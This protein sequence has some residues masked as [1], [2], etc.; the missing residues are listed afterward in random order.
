M[1]VAPRA[2]LA[3]AVVL[4]VVCGLG[5]LA[6]AVESEPTEVVRIH[7][8]TTND[9]ARLRQHH[10]FWGIDWRA[11]DAVFGLAP[12]QRAELRRAG[13]KLEIDPPRQAELNRWRALDHGRLL[14]GEPDTV[15]GFSCYRSV[16]KTHADLQ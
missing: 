5:G 15:P 13:F 8:L 12:L 9:I 6:D 14:V 3:L 16:A 2:V 7:G 11:G 4:A 1:S 10:D